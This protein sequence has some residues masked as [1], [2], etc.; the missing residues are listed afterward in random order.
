MDLSF[1]ITDDDILDTTIRDSETNS[2][3][4]TVETPRYAEGAL[5]T[6]ATRRNLVNGSTR[7]AFGIVWGGASLED[8]RVVL[9]HRTLEDVPVRQVLERASGNTT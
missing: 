5:T 3:M 4:Y 7:F 8:A 9:D 1:A 6:T 2:I